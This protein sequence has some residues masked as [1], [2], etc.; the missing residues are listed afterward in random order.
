MI[1]D[2]DKITRIKRLLKSRPKGLTIS[3][4]S[5]NLKINRNSVAKYLEILLITGQVEMRLY[6]NAKVYYLSQRVPISDMLK[7]ATELIL[8]LDTDLKI[9]DVN[10][11]FLRF[12]SLSREN[13][14][15]CEVKQLNVPALSS[16]N[17]AP[18][19][20]EEGEPG[21]FPRD[22][23]FTQNGEEK[24][25]KVKVVPTV[26][27]DGNRGLTLIIEDVTLPTQYEHELR[28]NEARYRAIVEDQTELICRFT[29]DFTSRLSMTRSVNI[30]E[31]AGKRS[32]VVRTLTSSQSKTGTW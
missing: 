25:L 18:L 12:F 22:I 24:H 21:E 10:E 1:L 15:G 7:F 26:F 28:I 29:P 31:R 11:N 14:L 8:I 20:E 32:S 9:A 27:D 2:Q 17:L 16:L 30:W 23:H 3:D 13:V 5:Q 6:G 4:V 19:P